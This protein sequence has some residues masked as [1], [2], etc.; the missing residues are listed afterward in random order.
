LKAV[1]ASR[2]LPGR[3]TVFWKNLVRYAFASASLPPSAM[4]EPHA[5]RMFQRADPDE[6]GLGVTI[7]TPGFTRSDQVLIPF[8]LPLRTTMTT[9]DW[10]AMPLVGPAFQSFATRPAS[11]S[12]VMSLSREK[13]TMSAFWPAAT[14]RLWSPEAPYEALKVTPLPADVFAKSANSALLGCSRIENPTRLRSVPVL[15]PLEL[16]PQPV[17]ARPAATRA[18]TRARTRRRPPPGPRACLDM[19]CSLRSVPRR[20]RLVR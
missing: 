15:L 16:A 18:A 19:Q 4:T 12:R 10:L 1:V 3:D 13:C 8:G 6:P 7:L 14:A 9:T 20:F 11:T 17:R 2:P 5:A